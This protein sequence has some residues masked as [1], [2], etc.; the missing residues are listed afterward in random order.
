[1][2]ESKDLESLDSARLVLPHALLFESGKA[3]LGFFGVV[4]SVSCL[5]SEKLDSRFCFCESIGL[6]SVVSLVVS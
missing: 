6:D 2:A 4:D 3:S 1:M 5:D